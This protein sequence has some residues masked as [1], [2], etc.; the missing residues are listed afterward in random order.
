M[1][2]KKFYFVYPC[3]VQ[4]LGWSDMFCAQLWI[5]PED[6]EEC[7]LFSIRMWCFTFIFLF[8]A[9]SVMLVHI[10]PNLIPQIWYAFF[11]FQPSWPQLLFYFRRIVSLQHIHRSAVMLQYCCA[12]VL[13]FLTW[14]I[15]EHSSASDCV[16]NSN[17]SQWKHSVLEVWVASSI[18]VSWHTW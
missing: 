5:F 4:R 8:E 2:T 7:L 17:Q 3:S 1:H 10:M 9:Q 12:K 18:I 14:K 6:I 16:Q 13:D 15:F 11:L